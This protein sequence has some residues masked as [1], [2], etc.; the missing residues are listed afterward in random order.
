[1]AFL[2]SPGEWFPTWWTLRPV[3]APVLAGWAGGPEAE[4]LSLR[5]RD[6]VAERALDSLTRLFGID[7]RA[8]EGLLEGW[9]FHDWQADP[10]ARGAYSYV[11]VGGSGAQQLLA[12]PVAETLFFAGEATHYE[13]ESGTVAAAIVSGKRAAAEVL[14]SEKQA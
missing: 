7:R 12:Q 4:K 14:E 8:L 2:H 5:G 9:Q 1:M 6:F 3:R 10:L 11:P 13:G